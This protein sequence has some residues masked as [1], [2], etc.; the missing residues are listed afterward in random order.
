LHVDTDG[1][2]YRLAFE[3]PGWEPAVADAIVARWPEPVLFGQRSMFFGG[4]HLVHTLDGS[5]HGVGDPRRGGAV[6]TV[7]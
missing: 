4:V 2:L 7:G 1:E 3:R 6:A 5:P